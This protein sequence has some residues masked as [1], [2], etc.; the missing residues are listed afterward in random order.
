VISIGR[1]KSR[2]TS[3]RHLRKEG[4]G[5]FPIRLFRTNNLKEGE[6]LHARQQAS[7]GRTRYFLLVFLWQQ[8]SPSVDGV[9]VMHSPTI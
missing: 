8:N 9:I 6:M 7:N 2:N 1:I 3:N 5:I 4:I